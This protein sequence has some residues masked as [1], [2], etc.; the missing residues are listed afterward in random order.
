MISRKPIIQ[1]IVF[2][3]VSAVFVSCNPNID[4]MNIIIEEVGSK[5]IHHIIC[6]VIAKS[7]DVKVIGE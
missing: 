1:I 3:I 2:F 4:S 5:R 6:W 7:N